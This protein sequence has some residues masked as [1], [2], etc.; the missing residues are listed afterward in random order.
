MPANRIRAPVGSTVAVAGSSSA[1]VSAGPTP[2]STPMAVPSV[3]PSRPSSRFLMLSATAK[4]LMSA[5]N[6]SMSGFQHQP[7][8]RQVQAQAAREQQEH[9]HRKRDGDRDV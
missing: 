4:P 9:Q 2:G 7:A 6:V 8:G 1:M 5:V 3:T